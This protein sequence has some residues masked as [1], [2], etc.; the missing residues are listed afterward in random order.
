MGTFLLFGSVSGN[1]AEHPFDTQVFIDIGPVHSFAIA[2]DFVI[3]V[4]EPE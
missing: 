1:A 4:A 3:P 2:D